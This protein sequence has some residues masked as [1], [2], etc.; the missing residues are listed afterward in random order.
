MDKIKSFVSKH[1]FAVIIVTLICVASI[2]AIAIISTLHARQQT[3]DANE[4]MLEMA[5]EEGVVI[6]EG[7]TVEEVVIAEGERTIDFTELQDRNDEIIAWIEIGGTRIDYPVTQGQDN[8]YYLTNNAL[9]EPSEAG[10]IY[11]DESNA[12]DFSDRNTIIYG[13]RMNNGDMFAELFFYQDQEFFENNNTIKIYEPDGVSEYEIFAAYETSDELIPY[14]WDVADD[15]VW[16]QY[17]DQIGESDD[18]PMLSD[19]EIADD[20]TIIT[21][22]TC[23]ENQDDRRYLVQ[24]VKV[25]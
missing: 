9:L 2:A 23:V 10:A 7:E 20:D 18:S 6:E 16:Q 3:Q 22:S 17:R 24:A 19:R 15:E 12:Y 25:S 5:S 14:Y 13:H 11:L 21:L 1:R 8:V 4:L